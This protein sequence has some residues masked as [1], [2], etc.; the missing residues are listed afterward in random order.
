MEMEMRIRDAQAL[1]R[2]MELKWRD[3]PVDSL[4]LLVADTKHNREILRGHP[5][6]FPRLARLTYR[7]LIRQLRAARHPPTALVL[8]PS[9]S[10]KPEVLRWTSGSWKEG[11]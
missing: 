11:S 1:E 6:L 2:R 8:V 4:V 9:P 10:K 3:D 7:E 5:N